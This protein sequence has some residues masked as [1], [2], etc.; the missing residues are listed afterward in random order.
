MLVFFVCF[1]SAILLIGD[2]PGGAARVSV[3]SLG[4]AV[5]VLVRIRSGRA[6]PGEVR[7][8]VI[9]FTIPVLLFA[10]AQR[11]ASVLTLSSL[12]QSLESSVTSTECSFFGIITDISIDNDKTLYFI[13]NASI[14]SERL[15]VDGSDG[16]LSGSVRVTLASRD[17]EDLGVGTY[18]TGEG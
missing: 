13:D 17:R 7:A 2:S 8:A 9:F 6:G 14:R 10:A 4:C 18:V 3:L 5:F 16:L 15:D 1:A 11:T 12:R